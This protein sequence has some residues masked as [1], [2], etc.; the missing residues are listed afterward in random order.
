LCALSGERLFVGGARWLT[1]VAVFNT[2]GVPVTPGSTV[3]LMATD[4]A[5][6]LGNYKMAFGATITC[7][8]AR[9]PVGKGRESR[10]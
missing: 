8:T 5:T 7:A 6:F 9:R 1:P 4:N 3:Q 10:R 2:A